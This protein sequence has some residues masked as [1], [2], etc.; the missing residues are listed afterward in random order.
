MDDP[1]LIAKKTTEL[2]KLFAQKFGAKTG[3]LETRVRK[4]GRRLPKKVR[5]DLATVLKIQHL[6]ENPKLLPQINEAEFLAAQ[7]R[8]KAFLQ[9]IDVKDRRLG[10]VL[11]VLGSTAFNL[12]ALFVLLVLL[13]LWR[14]FV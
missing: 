9:D 13:L 1:S 11:G 2:E 12:I 14:G 7:E 10:V 6:S 4:A 8:V 5:A 3:P